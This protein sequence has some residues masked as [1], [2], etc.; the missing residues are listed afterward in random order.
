M[1]LFKHVGMVKVDNS[2]GKSLYMLGSCSYLSAYCIS[3]IVQ[4]TLCCFAVGEPWSKR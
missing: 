3:Q 1:T 2:K 4:D